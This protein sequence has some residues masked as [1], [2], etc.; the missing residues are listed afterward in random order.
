MDKTT[1]QNY[2]DE[3]FKRLMGQEGEH[4]ISLKWSIWGEL[5][6]LGELGIDITEQ[7]VKRVILGLSQDKASGPDGFPIFFYKKY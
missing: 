3:Y 4:I 2:I 1:I 5:T 6:D 7:E